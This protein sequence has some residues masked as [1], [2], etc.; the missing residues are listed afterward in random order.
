MR[1][2]GLESNSSLLSPINVDLHVER[3]G[4]VVKPRTFGPGGPRFK[5]LSRRLLWP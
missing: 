5:S 3:T 2:P 1:G 4:A